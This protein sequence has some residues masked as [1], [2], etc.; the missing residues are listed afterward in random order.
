MCK[1]VHKRTF[2][3]ALLAIPSIGRKNHTFTSGEIMIAV[4]S[5]NRINKMMTKVVLDR[6]LNEKTNQSIQESVPE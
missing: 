6:L 5:C 3:G 4:Y 1:N 2:I